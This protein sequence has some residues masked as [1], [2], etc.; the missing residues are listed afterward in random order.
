MSGEVASLGSANAPAGPE[1]PGGITVSAQM[2]AYFR[3]FTAVA[4]LGISV[5][6][7]FSLISVF[8]SFNLTGLILGL[9]L[10][11]TGCIIFVVECDQVPTRVLY[12]KVVGQFPFLKHYIG[13]AALY[14]FV[15]GQCLALGSTQGYVLGIAFMAISV[16]GFVYGGLH[17]SPRDGAPGVPHQELQEVQLPP[18]ELETKQDFGS[19][20]GHSGQQATYTTTAEPVPEMAEPGSKSL[21]DAEN[22][23]DT[24]V[25]AG[26]GPL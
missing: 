12:D 24:G 2:M 14:L 10:F 3:V 22:P 4:G 1:G 9:Y 23:F 8:M 11:P 26:Q 15:A 6:M 20:F 13:R 18:A 16:I 17:P 7:V 21:A 25:Q 5:G 19:E